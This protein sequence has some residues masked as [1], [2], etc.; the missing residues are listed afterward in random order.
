MST[1]SLLFRGYEE[2][3]SSLLGNEKEDNKP[4]S[5]WDIVDTSLTWLHLRSTVK[6]QRTIFENMS[7]FSFLFQESSSSLLGDEKK[8]TSQIPAGTL[9]I[10]FSPNFI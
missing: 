8:T 1:Y 3:S 2:S 6:S 4:D 7:T 9:W 5:N 10:Q